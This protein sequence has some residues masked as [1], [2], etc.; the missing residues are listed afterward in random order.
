MTNWS[1]SSLGMVG[2]F[3]AAAS[4]AFVVFLLGIH[5]PSDHAVP[6]TQNS[7]QAQ[8]K[9]FKR[10]FM[11]PVFMTHSP[12]ESFVTHA[13]NLR[14]DLSS[15][16]SYEAVHTQGA[17]PLTHLATASSVI[18]PPGHRTAGSYHWLLERMRLRYAFNDQ[19]R[20]PW[21]LGSTWPVLS[22]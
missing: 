6:R 12:C 4:A 17:S 20:V 10:H 13:A 9:L 8:T 5:A 14:V 2:N 1:M 21:P 11:L 3:A 16:R 22:M 7:G 19:L 18:A 15:A